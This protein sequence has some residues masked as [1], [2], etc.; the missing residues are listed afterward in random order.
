MSGIQMARQGPDSTPTA[1]VLSVLCDSRS[2]RRKRYPS[3]FHP[4]VE[5]RQR[6]LTLQPVPLLPVANLF[7]ERGQE[8]KR[9]VCRL[10]VFRVRMS[11]IMRQ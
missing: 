11:H 10:K 4:P 8:I 5:L 2:T 9:D 1:A 7:L 6:Q 3:P